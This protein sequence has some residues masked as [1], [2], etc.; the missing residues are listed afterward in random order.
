[1]SDG[2]DL[3]P[4]IQLLDVLSSR[5]QA[6]E[7][8]VQLCLQKSHRRLGDFPAVWALLADSNVHPVELI[9]NLDPENTQTNQHAKPP[10]VPLFT[11][12]HLRMPVP[13]DA[14]V[15]S[16]V[17]RSEA[18]KTSEF[19]REIQSVEARL[20][21]IR[22]SRIILKSRVPMMHQKINIIQKIMNMFPDTCE[23]LLKPSIPK[24]LKSALS[25]IHVFIDNSNIL[26][27]FYEHIKRLHGL[28]RNDNIRRPGLSFQGLTFIL[29]RGRTSAK[30]VLVGSS[31]V[32]PEVLEAR[33]LGYEVSIL[34]RV[35]KQVYKAAN[36]TSSGSETG[37]GQRRVH[38]VEQAVDEIIHLKILE[39]LLD[40][41]PSTIVLA[42]GDG[43]LGEFSLGFLKV[44]ERC[45][46][47]GWTVEIVSFKRTLSGVYREKEFRKRWKGK[48]RVILLDAFAMDLLI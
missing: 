31:P 46:S 33:E 23:A 14:Q 36:F 8:I 22:Q 20:T 38:K 4:V 5:E 2:F 47:R 16:P 19:T 34:E 15:Y 21:P 43:N 28:S 42:S 41:K 6:V 18:S 17:M 9:V 37:T 26:I 25:D 27:G 35:E 39:S 45:L 13:S 11:N 32:T 24:G 48:F 10:S 40:Y 7:P 29:E 30:K 3:S 44:I 1:M 12:S